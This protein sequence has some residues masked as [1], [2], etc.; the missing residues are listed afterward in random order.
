MFRK[1]CRRRFVLGL[2]GAL[3]GVTVGRRSVAA[4][5]EPDTPPPTTPIVPTTAGALCA[6]FVYD[7]T[8]RIRREMNAGLSFSYSNDGRHLRG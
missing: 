5:T 3:F 4:P 6:T 2:M 8:D 7:A 1:L